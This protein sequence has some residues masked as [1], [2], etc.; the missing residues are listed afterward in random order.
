MWTII[1]TGRPH[2]GFVSFNSRNGVVTYSSSSIFER[3]TVHFSS[4]RPANQPEVFVIFPSPSSP[5][6]GWKFFLF[7]TESGPAL[8]PTKPPIQWVLG[9]VFLGVKLL[10]HEAD[11]S[12]PSNAEVKNAW[13]YTST[14]PYAFMAW[15]P[16]RA[17]G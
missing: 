12:C 17:Q 9:A 5:G 7:P 13:S 11:H 1:R 10:G 6:R 8:G 2:C 4:R 3:F 14:P 16:V 15:C